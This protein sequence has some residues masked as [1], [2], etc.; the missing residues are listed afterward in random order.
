MRYRALRNAV[1]ACLADA[2]SS[3][4]QPDSL[5]ILL[6]EA[7]EHVNLANRLHAFDRAGWPR[8]LT[9]ERRIR[10]TF[11]KLPDPV[12]RGLAAAWLGAADRLVAERVERSRMRA[13][14]TVGLG[15][16][17]YNGARRGDRR[18]PVHPLGATLFAMLL[19]VEDADPGVP[20]G[21]AASW[22]PPSSLRPSEPPVTASGVRARPEAEPVPSRVGGTHR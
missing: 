1:S 22:P 13:C 20:L 16:D 10:S 2:V 19:A 8:L 12:R 15:R 17:A 9:Y 21:V 14:L 6:E 7:W 5:W 11:Q 4:M 18:T 3:F